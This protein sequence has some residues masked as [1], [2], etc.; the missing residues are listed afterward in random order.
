MVRE[1]Q[2]H[3][4]ELRQERRFDNKALQREVRHNHR[5]GFWVVVV[6]CVYIIFVYVSG[7]SLLERQIEM[8]Q[9][10]IRRM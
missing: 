5:F 6:T 8:A 1:T 10:Q 2:R 4:Q 9:D 3:V 7:C